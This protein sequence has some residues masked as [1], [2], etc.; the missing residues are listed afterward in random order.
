VS[1]VPTGRMGIGR[2]HPLKGKRAETRFTHHP[3][4]GVPIEGA[5]VP[6]WDRVC[7]TVLR[8]AKTLAVHRYVGWDVVVD[9]T[10]TPMII[11]GNG[12][13]DVNLLQVHGG[14][15][16]DPAVRRFYEKCGVV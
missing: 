1:A 5:V 12:N 2:M 6:H 7:D 10:G 13:T 8:A 4:T 3:D 15:L 9:T 11:E 16:T 14:L